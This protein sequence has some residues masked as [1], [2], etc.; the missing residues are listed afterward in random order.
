M[1]KEQ[2]SE[3][4]DRGVWVDRRGGTVRWHPSACVPRTYPPVLN[5]HAEES[6]EDRE[7]CGRGKVYPYGRA[8]SPWTGPGP[9]GRPRIHARRERGGSLQDARLFYVVILE[10]L[11]GRDDER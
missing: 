11:D 3:E 9:S 7:D 6:G 10:A 2:E 1:A 5:G 4:A 8:S